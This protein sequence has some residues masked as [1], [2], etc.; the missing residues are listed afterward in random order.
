MTDQSEQKTPEVSQ[1]IAFKAETRQLLDILIH[2]LYTEREIFLRELISNAS[3][4]LTRMNFEIQKNRDILDPD[5]ELAITI[6]SNPQ[7]NTLTI[8]DTGIGMTSEELVE[9]L[10]TIAHSGAKAFVTAAQEGAK[11]LSDI[12]GRFG[13][14]FYSAFMV[15]ESIKVISRSQQPETSAASWYCTGDDTFIVEPAQKIDRGTTVII[16]LKE[17]AK[18]FA[19]ENRLREVIKKHS[20]F[21]SFPIYLGEKKEQANQQTALWRQAPR[22]VEK[23]DYD[24]FYHQLTL[25][26]S[27]PLIHIHLSVD[28]PVQMYAI[29]YV[30]SKSERNMFSIRKEDG[31]KLYSCNVLIQE[32]CRDVL[33]EYY[34]FI[35]GVVDTEDIPLNVS[36]E[37][38]QANRIMVNLK[39]LITSKVTASLEKLAKDEPDNYSKFWEEYGHYVKEGVVV[40]QTELEFLYPLLRYHTTNFLDQWSSL[41]DYLGRMKP[42]QDN[43]YYIL[44]DDERSVVYSPHLDIIRKYG[45]EVLLLTEPIDPFMVVRLAKYKD[46]SL[47]NVSSPALKLPSIEMGPEGETIPTLGPED[48]ISLIQR[49]KS[50]LG[51]KVTDVRMTDRLSGSP[52][53]LVDPEGAPNQEMQR[54]YR[55]LQEDF[56]TQIKVLELNPQ[57]PI[58]MQLSTLPS[59]AELSQMIIDQ[60]YEDALLIE[61]LHPDPAGMIERIQKIIAAAIK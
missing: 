48:W 32:Y 7:S 56:K 24:D 14:G 34:R 22:K 60:I 19:Q 39:K 33:P 41:D 11:N 23:K 52:A 28:A 30:P 53:R 20:D 44:G 12:I 59:E 35:Q 57:H 16:T 46:H 43:I 40:E 58:I 49:F 31:V 27:L 26:F 21:I 5:V 55:L 10:G 36:R 38:I 8:S 50:Q 25:E 15:A 4:A 18:E 3:D 51:E 61:G 13:V 1:P 42:E 17:D 9:N 54:M 45:F 2:S 6:I 37:T 29:L 47:V